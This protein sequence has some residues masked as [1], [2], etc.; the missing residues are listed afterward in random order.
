MK[1][2]PR[3]L[4]V[5]LQVSIQSPQLVHWARLIK[6]KFL[7]SRS[8][9]QDFWHGGDALFEM[10][11]FLVKR[12]L[13]PKGLN[14]PAII[15][16]IDCGQIQLHHKRFRKINSAS[17]MAIKNQ[18]AQKRYFCINRYWKIFEYWKGRDT[19]FNTGCLKKIIVTRKPAQKI[20]NLITIVFF[21]SL[22][23]IEAVSFLIMLLIGLINT[24][25]KHKKKIENIYK[26][27]PKKYRIMEKTKMQYWKMNR[28]QR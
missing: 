15:I 27:Y 12:I 6:F 4:P 20:M 26:D 24:L 11:F 3:A 25:L 17:K 10:Q 19:R 28:V 16:R 1:P 2:K 13:N 23:L 14:N 22:I 5:F 7:G 18:T 21:R 9:E 8:R